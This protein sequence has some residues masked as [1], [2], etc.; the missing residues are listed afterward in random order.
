MFSKDNI[1]SEAYFG[2]LY[3]LRHWLHQHPELSMEEYQTSRFIYQYLCEA[4]ID[5]HMAGETGVIGTILVNPNYRTIAVRAEIDALPICEKT[6]LP[7]A[8]LDFGKMHAC[9]HDAITAVVLCLA[10]ILA[11]HPENLNY[12]IRFL[13]EPGEETGQGA[14]YL[15][16]RGG[17]ENPK[18]DE[19]LIFHYGNQEPRGMEIQKD[20]T[21][22]AVGG[23]T[24]HVKGKASHWFDPGSGKDALY[25]ASRLAVEIHE[26]NR[27]LST[28]YPFVLGFGLLQAGTAGNIV[29]D[30]A[31]L[32][33]SLRAFTEQD[34]ALVEEKLIEKI[35]QV[36][37]ETDTEITLEHGQKIPPMRNDPKLVKKGAAIGQKLMKE[38][39]FLGEKP[40]LVGDNAAYYLEK[41]PGMRTVFL[42]GKEGETAYP[43]HNPQFDIDERVMIDALEF[44]YQ[45]LTKE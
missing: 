33:G 20:I 22:A 25:A 5:C 40:F 39:F 16:D 6:K 23:L 19:I 24:I 34:F 35:N 31:V 10:K 21:T 2:E 9:G 14:R 28:E 42:A 13:F 7:F 30:N 8:S 4:G 18:V 1:P 27:T 29:A 3:R 12:N 17:L 11:G 45:M 26:L 36:A 43:V 41:V 32:K 38:R 15:I 37:Q 44:L